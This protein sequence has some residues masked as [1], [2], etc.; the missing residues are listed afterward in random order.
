[1]RRVG[2]LGIVLGGA[3]LGCHRAPPVDVLYAWNRPEKLTALPAGAEVAVYA[4]TVSLQADDVVWQPRH[5][6]A[7]RRERGKSPS[8]TIEPPCVGKPP[9]PDDALR[10]FVVG[11]IAQ[12]AR[13]PGV[14]EIQIDYEAPLSEREFLRALIVDVRRALDAHTRLSMTA[15][16]SWCLYDG[17]LRALPVD[18]VV[19]MVYRMGRDRQPV[20][21][22]LDEGHDFFVPLCDH[23]VAVSLADPPPR[24]PP[25]QRR[26]VFNPRA[27]TS[28]DLRA[29]LGKTP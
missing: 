25:L 8:F 15:L 14:S 23:A 18:D 17:W 1:M 4:A 3:T 6:G 12:V 2:W 13:A 10:A 16:A 21:K 11:K 7:Y 9:L 19:P 28:D 24:L 29:V 22:L 26:F 20:R 5:A 27:W